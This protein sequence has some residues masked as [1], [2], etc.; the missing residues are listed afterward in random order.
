[1]K[2]ILDKAEKLPIF[3]SV[4]D[5]DGIN[6]N[7]IRLLTKKFAKDTNL[8]MDFVFS[9]LFRKTCFIV[10]DK[11]EGGVLSWIKKIDS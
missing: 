10:I 5:I 4:K 7:D 11:T 1:M 9:D 3:I 2:E 8:N 6:S